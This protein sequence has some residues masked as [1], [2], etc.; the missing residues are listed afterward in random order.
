MTYNP[1]IPLA[2]DF[3]SSSQNDIK[4]NFF[5]I[6]EQFKIDHVALDAAANNGAHKQINFKT[7]LVADVTCATTAGAVY[8]KAVAGVAELFFS[9]SSNLSNRLTGKMSVVADGYAYLPGGLIV[10]WGSSTSFSPTPVV[11]AMA[12]PTA[13][14][15]VLLTNA[16]TAP[17]YSLS[18][19]SI[20][21]GRDRFTVEKGS[22]SGT[23]S[24]YY[25]AIGH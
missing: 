17:N 13:C 25:I 11:L 5:Q 2:T 9:N 4:T 1:G 8:T 6:N 12:F 16:G 7:P 23:A 3:I 20:G 18:V 19:A 24:F 15:S 21:V 14:F 10:Q 22:G